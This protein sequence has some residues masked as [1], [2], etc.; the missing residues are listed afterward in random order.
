M[1]WRRQL[2]CCFPTYFIPKYGFP[3]VG[4]MWRAHFTIASFEKD[5]FTEA[6]QQLGKLAPPTTTR[7]NKLVLQAI[8]PDCVEL[9]KEW[10]IKEND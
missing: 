1:T 10:S 7:I 5:V 9:L 4:D 6:W 2:A 8:Q 3:F